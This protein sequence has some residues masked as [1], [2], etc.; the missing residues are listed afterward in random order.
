MNNYTF[1]E[2]QRARLSYTE[3]MTAFN[4]T[5]LL[6]P[7]EG[8]PFPQA[9]SIEKLIKLIL[10]LNI[11]NLSSSQIAKL[12]NFTERQAYYYTSAGMYFGLIDKIHSTRLYTLTP[13]CK[14]AIQND[15]TNFVKFFVST[16][17]KDKVF[18]DSFK[19]F[20]EKKDN[21]SKDDIY[22]VLLTHELSLDS[23]S[24]YKRRASTVYNFVTW[25]SSR[26]Y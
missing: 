15:P 7:P 14:L 13:K 20:I 19:T 24:T 16:I 1:E 4:Q 2:V 3:I 17:L 5:E 22:Y 21:F 11:N 26:L 8:I 12:F 25:I 9:N 23:A 6:D 18:N 10:H